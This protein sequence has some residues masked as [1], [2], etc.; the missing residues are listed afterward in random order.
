M[1][2]NV[3]GS[4][5]FR[6]QSVQPKM[7]DRLAI[8]GL[9]QAL[10]HQVQGRDDLELTRLILASF[11]DLA[12]AAGGDAPLPAR[13]S[14]ERVRDLESK[15]GNAQLVAVA[16]ARIELEGLAAAWTA[17]SALV[18]ARTAE[19]AHAKRLSAHS[20]GLSVHAQAEAELAAI[21]E[22]RTLLAEPDPVTSV[23]NDL[24]DALRSVL[25]ERHG[26]YVAARDTA[27]AAL[28]RESDWTDLEK[29]SQEKIL[30]A[31]RLD[32]S[33]TPKVGTLEELLVA[34]DTTPLGDW[35]FRVQAV[36]NQA[37][38]ALAAAA[39][40]KPSPTVELPH[41]AAVIHDEPE[42]ETYLKKIRDTVAP[43]LAAGKT[44]I[45]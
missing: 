18:P 31:E 19:W 27:I 14:T 4:V 40:R 7:A 45:L 36:P 12:Y 3:I 20:G 44:V 35:Q 29:E 32:G 28:D 30:Q 33:G 25:L 17:S 2:Q 1:P 8:R 9:W 42:L 6:P 13:P 41:E 24:A 15:A 38:A 16:H 34:L 5:E 23:V 26:A 39:K 10:G 22:A 37:A 11:H 43:H 21:G